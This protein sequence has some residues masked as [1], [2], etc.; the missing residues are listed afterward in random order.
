MDYPLVMHIDQS[1]SGISQL[2]R[3]GDCQCRA[4]ITAPNEK[5]TSSSRF[6]WKFAFT[7]SLMLPFT[8]HSV[9]ITSRSS[10]VVTPNNGNT[11]GWRR[12]LHPT[13][14]LQKFYKTLSVVNS[15][16][17]SSTTSNL[18][19]GPAQGHSLYMSLEPWLRPPGHDS[20]PSTHPRIRLGTPGSPLGRSRAKFPAT[21]EPGLGGHR[22]C[23]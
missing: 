14:S 15:H 17:K 18:L 7:N 22:S 8:I 20:D 3:T 19:F 2:R 5:H 16:N 4:E 1:L 21:A 11:F 12:D 23:I 13:T 6:A 9:I 10:V